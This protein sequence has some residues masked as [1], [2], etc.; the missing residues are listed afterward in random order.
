MTQHSGNSGELLTTQQLADR[1]SFKTRATLD[2][3]RNRGQGPKWVDISPE[4]SKKPVVRYRIEDV[5][6]YET[7]NN[8]K[9]EV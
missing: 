2:T 3:W 9:E 8:V 1:W 7:H 4:G 5:V 6:Y